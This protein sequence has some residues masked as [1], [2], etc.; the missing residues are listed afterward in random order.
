[1]TSIHSSSNY[2]E[3]FDSKSNDLIHCFE[4]STIMP[5]NVDVDSL[6]LKEDGDYYIKFWMG[7]IEGE[8]SIYLFD[9]E[10]I[11]TEI[12]DNFSVFR[13]TNYKSK[14]FQNY[15]GF[16]WITIEST[17]R[18]WYSQ[19]F[20][21]LTKHENVEV[22]GG[23][24]DYI[25]EEE[26]NLLVD[27]Y[28][29][30][31]WGT[32]KGKDEAEPLTEFFVKAVSVISENMPFIMMRPF[33][34]ITMDS[35]NNTVLGRGASV[36]INK[37]FSLIKNNHINE[38]NS[39]DLFQD[40]YSNISVE[41]NSL[42]LCW[43]HDLLIVIDSIV[44]EI[45]KPSPKPKL[46]VGYQSLYQYVEQRIHLQ[47]DT[48]LKTLLKSKKT[49]ELYYYDLKK[50]MPSV[51]VWR[52][53]S[54]RYTRRVFSSLYY[55]KMFSI[56]DEWY[57]KVSVSPNSMQ[58]NF[59]IVRVD[60]IFELFCLAKLKKQ[61]IEL[62]YLMES[63]QNKKYPKHHKDLRPSFN[64]KNIYSYSKGISKLILFY[65]P[66]IIR[67]SSLEDTGLI[68]VAN[69]QPFRTP[70][71]VIKI[72]ENGF[73]KYLILDAKYSKPKTARKEYLP[74]LV[75]KYFHGLAGVN[76]DIISVCTISTANIKTKEKF[77]SNYIEGAVPKIIIGNI[78]MS[79]N[80]SLAL[81]DYFKNINM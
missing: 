47:K 55:T 38:I 39:E 48:R 5:T 70:D 22:I 3:V 53:V 27:T 13:S 57:K 11:P 56:M 37:Y 26:P 80:N 61:I 65:E 58:L 25:L 33:R 54:F 35:K 41:E 66:A 69:N 44:C 77:E 20:E 34:K 28:S 24:V 4:L 19:I 50:Q 6:Q 52:K 9:T 72:Q 31:R 62:G 79:I 30:I 40:I 51:N 32:V 68:T 18:K 78:P 10:I 2:I 74:G 1:M 17:N 45:K 23:Y 15:V 64:G 46:I 71:Y 43:L 75:W 14:L 42:I 60:V 12:N 16:L 49:I 7:T 21:V 59:S 63:S 8:Y 76:G 29:P 73:D 81:T 36:D 67:N